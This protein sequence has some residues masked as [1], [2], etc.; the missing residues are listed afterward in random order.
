ML[1]ERGGARFGARGGF[2]LEDVDF[3]SCDLDAGGFGGLVWAHAAK[4]QATSTIKSKLRI[5]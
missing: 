4:L 5:K 2:G 1:S 3:G